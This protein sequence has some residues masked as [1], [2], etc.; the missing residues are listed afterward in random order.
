MTDITTNA[1]KVTVG[2]DTHKNAHVAVAADSLGHRLGEM[3]VPTT[4]SG[5]KTLE[6]WA[7]GFG[8]IEAFGIEGTGSYGAGLCRYL[9]TKGYQVTEVNRPDRAMRRSKGKSD[10]VDA[11][12]AARS[13]L[14]GMATA[15]PKETNA[16]VETI[17]L[18][19]VARQ[20]AMKARTAAII[21]LQSLL[22]S[23]PEKL[24]EEL[25]GLSSIKLVR[26]CSRFRSGNITDVHS[27][28]K[29][30]LRS[31]ARRYQSLEDEIKALEKQLNK[32]V[33]KAAPTLLG[34]FGVGP[35]VAST[36]LIAAGENPQR[37]R[38][39][40]ALAG[41]FGTSPVLA[42]SGK[43][44]RHRLNRGGN[45]Q[46]NSA[47]HTIAMSRLAHDERTQNYMAKRIAEGKSKREAMRCLK[48]YI[49]REIY[50]ALLA[51]GIYRTSQKSADMAA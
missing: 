31:V 40:A 34:L 26:V 4:M 39:D 22:I 49:T 29:A 18:L 23:A 36:L 17:R 10:P 7:E 16:E 3:I 15:T 19:K 5:F 2:V 25:C 48:R 11:E 33:P 46:A 1:S 44:N 27:A 43:T 13:V 42:S 32:L 21:T 9:Q 37:I 24:R 47:L 28:A 12:A 45:R 38:S 20:G 6:D 41:L 30:S 35:E 8:S 50:Q 51:D 14:S